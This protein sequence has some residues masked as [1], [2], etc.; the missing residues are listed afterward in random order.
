VDCPVVNMEHSLERPVERILHEVISVVDRTVPVVV[1]VD[2]EIPVTIDRTVTVPVHVPFPVDRTVTVE[3]EKL[4]PVPVT[5]VLETTVEKTVERTTVVEVEVGVKPSLELD[6][7]KR[8]VRRV[9]PEE[10]EDDSEE[11]VAGEGGYGLIGADSDSAPCDGL[12][13]TCSQLSQ[14]SSAY[15]CSSQ[16]S[17]ASVNLYSTELQEVVRGF[18]VCSR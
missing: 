2:R 5:T 4:V 10:V 11:E 18:R 7:R 14:Q 3:V 17:R 9:E 1:T 13:V 16:A 6:M 12:V 8:K 15:F